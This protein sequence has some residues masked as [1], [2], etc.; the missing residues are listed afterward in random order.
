MAHTTEI[1][2]DDI[3]GIRCTRCN[4]LAPITADELTGGS[5]GKDVHGQ[6]IKVMPTIV[7]TP[8]DW[9][10]DD[11]GNLVCPACATRREHI[12]WEAGQQTVE[13]TVDTIAAV[14]RDEISADDAIRECMVEDH[15]RDQLDDQLDDLEDHDP[16]GD[17]PHTLT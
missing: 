13:Q 10:E 8:D 1:E 7:A 17:D 11:D 3:A 15:R 14:D 5:R 16:R 9:P 4:R 6:E 12:E 2:D